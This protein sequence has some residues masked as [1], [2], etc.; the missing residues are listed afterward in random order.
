MSRFRLAAVLIPAVAVLSLAAAS[1][2]RKDPHGVYGVIDRVVFEPSEANPERIQLW[3]VFA[4]ADN[5]KVEDGKI[6]YMQAGIF[7]PA[8][9]GYLYYTVNPRDP[10]G[11][12]AQWEEMKSLAGTRRPVGFGAPFPPHA[13]RPGVTR[14]QMMVDYAR[15]METYNGRLRLAAETPASPDTFPL[16]MQGL[17]GRSVRTDSVR[18]VS[19][20]LFTVPDTP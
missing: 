18:A 7:H 2:V 19:R 15:L 20:G 1:T 12:R 8:R 4:L 16:Q 10:S 3:G 6:T 9:R 5:A 13:L 17:E 14:S 11:T